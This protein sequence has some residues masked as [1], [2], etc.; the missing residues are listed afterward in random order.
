[1]RTRAQALP[2]V[3]GLPGTRLTDDEIQVL[4][5]VRPVGVILFKRNIESVEQTLDLVAALQELEPAPFLCIDLE[6]GA[7]N[8]V[9]GLW[10]PLPS[11]ARSA[12]VGRRA[13]RLLGEA[14][15]AACRALGIHLDLA[16]VVDLARPEGLVARERRCF[17]D[18]PE[19]VATLAAVFAEG[20]AAWCVGGCLKHFPGLG[21]VELDTHQS[22]PTLDLSEEKLAPHLAAFS[23]LSET[24]PVVMTAHVIVPALGNSHTPASLCQDI[25]QRAATLPGNPVVLTD[26]LEMGAVA[27]LGTLP[28]L[29]VR[30]LGAG[31]HGV[32]VCNAFDRLQEIAAEIA[33]QSEADP[34]LSTRLEELTARLGTLRRD[35]CHK[36][37]S[38]P[39]PDSATVEQLFKRAWREVEAT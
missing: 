27:G 4:E 38:V 3:V 30:A 26:D 22:L 34:R 39:A 25:V 9:S 32:L 23:S 36:A 21:A 12:E 19:R 10:G 11:P 24:I 35:L 18:Q 33:D 28:E 20:L 7:I 13:V 8:R 31:N 29:V 37:A 1:M 2:L 17:S 15:G 6:G 5:Q 14:A 16:P